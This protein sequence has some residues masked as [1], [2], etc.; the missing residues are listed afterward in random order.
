MITVASWMEGSSGFITA[1]RIHEGTGPVMRRQAAEIEIE[2]QREAAQIAAGT[3]ARVVLVEKVGVAVQALVQSHGLGDIRPNLMLFGVANLRGSD[4]DREKYGRMLQN[5]IRFGTNV[6]VINVRDDAWERFESTPARERTIAL[7]WSDDVVGQLITLLGWLC[8]RHGDWADG[9]IIVYVPQMADSDEKSRIEGVLEDARIQAT[10]VE[11]DPTPA[12]FSAAL[13][14]ATLAL[15]PLRVR[16]GSATGP[17]N[18]PLGMLVESLPLAAMILAT[19]TIDL[20]AE[21]DEGAHAEFAKAAERASA[22]NKWVAELDAKAATL[23]VAAEAIRL[24][25][26]V[27]DAGDDTTAGALRTRLDEA[28]TEAARA[29]RLYV[30][31]KSRSRQLERRAAELDPERLGHSLD[32]EIWRS[33]TDDRDGEPRPDR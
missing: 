20:D 13:G 6:A 32:P 21:A 1:V 26:E 33:S 12:A 30:D 7:W 22:A 9:S 8:T 14:A 18:T 10:V 25:L 2:L 31:A 16:H 4:E 23:L 19:E 5:C 11:V 3:Y 29:Y 24:E 15:A 17:F 28:E 27:V